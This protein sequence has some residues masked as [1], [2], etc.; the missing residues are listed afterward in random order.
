MGADPI[1]MGLMVASSIF[2]GVTEHNALNADA[3]VDDE[4]ARRSVLDGALQGEEIRRQERAVS[5]EAVAA[6]GA[7]GVAIG[8]GSA[9]DLLRQNAV[10]R[11]YDVLNKRYAA[12]T[13]A[14]AYRA[15]A[16]QKRKAGT[17][18]LFGGL[19]NAGSAAL[20]QGASS[21]AAAKVN[22]A[23]VGGMALPTPRG[24]YG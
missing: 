6:M 13:Q 9:L 22:A 23:Q 24:T 4:N 2:K 18:A 20:T 14:D 7:N 16:K 15:Q 12:G 8:T 3:K 21:G 10:E 17:F 11:E 19:L 1:S 5:G